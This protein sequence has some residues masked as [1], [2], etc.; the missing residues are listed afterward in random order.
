MADFKYYMDEFQDSKV[1]QL[2]NEHE[3][4]SQSQTNT[5]MAAMQALK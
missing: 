1:P 5:N 2:S 4:L 3:T